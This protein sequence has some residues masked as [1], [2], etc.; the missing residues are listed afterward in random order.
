MGF[1]EK[2][3]SDCPPRGCH[4]NG[5]LIAFRLCLSAQPSVTDFAS[6]AAKDVA[7]PEG[8]DLCRWSSCSLFT[9]LDTVKKK[10]NTFKKLKKF[11]HVAELAIG[12]KAGHSLESN[13]HIDF[14]MFD[15]FDPIAAIVRV[16]TL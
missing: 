7:V 4:Q 3:P 2:L 5:H 13:K 1:R 8:V 11:V 9:D 16:E 14:W 15:T 10:R 12:P 6:E